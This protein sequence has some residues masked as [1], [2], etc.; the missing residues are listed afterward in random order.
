MSSRRGF[1]QEVMSD[2]GTN[3]VGAYS[4]LRDLINQLDAEKIKIS[5]ANKRIKWH[6]NP[7]YGPHFG[8]VDKTMIKL[9]KKAIYGILRSA[10]VTDEELVTAFAGA[11]D[12]INSRPLAYGSSDIKNNVPLTPNH[13]LIGRSGGYF[14]GTVVDDTRYKLQK[15]WRHTQELL[16]TVGEVGYKN[17]YLV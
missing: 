17:G 16:K 11:E 4:E 8:G 2:N 15:R 6:F 10:D 12:M 13:F 3:S 1:S 7:P 14:A 9:A 5:T